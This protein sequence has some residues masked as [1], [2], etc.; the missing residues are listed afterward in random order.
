MSTIVGIDSRCGFAIEVRHRNQPNKCKL[1][2][3]KP[4]LSLNKQQD[5]ALQLFRWVWCDVY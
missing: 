2:L 4:L 5:G 3:Y 1:V